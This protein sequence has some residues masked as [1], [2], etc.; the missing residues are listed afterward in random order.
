[1]ERWIRARPGAVVIHSAAV[2]DYEA[3]ALTTKIPS[4]SPELVL[5][6]HP[7]PKILDQVRGW[8]PDVF[9]VS[10]KAG[11]PELSAAELEAIARAQLRRTG[12]DLVFAN[13]LGA[14]ETTVLLVSEATTEAFG[15]RADAIA[16]L[17]A[18]IPA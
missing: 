10:F 13:V 3:A 7:A 8:A 17:C 2:G 9:L 1:M 12:S 6:L 14:I 5:R 15:R 4:G 16:A 18:R 11:S